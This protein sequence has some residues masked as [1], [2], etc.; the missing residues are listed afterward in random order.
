ML[1]GFTGISGLLAEACQRLVLGICGET[2][3]FGSGG[4]WG[5]QFRMRSWYEPCEG[6]W[7]R[8]FMP[9]EI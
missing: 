5:L 8:A 9:N 6:D 1:G 3:G 2:G 4:F 7:I